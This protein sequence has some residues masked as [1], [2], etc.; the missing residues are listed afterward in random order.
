MLTSPREKRIGTPTHVR[1]KW[2]PSRALLLTEPTMPGR[3]NS[4]IIAILAQL[5]EQGFCKAQ[6]AGSSP[7]NGP[8]GC[9][10]AVT[11]HPSKLESRVRSP[12]PAFYIP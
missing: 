1:E 4:I 7:V 11:R 12:S 2:D 6:V 9:G 8:S 5:V 3:S 10:V